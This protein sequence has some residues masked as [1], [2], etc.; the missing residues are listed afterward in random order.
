ML[1]QLRLDK[2]FDKLDE[3]RP[4]HASERDAISISLWGLFTTE[5]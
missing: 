5:R 1:K 3:S 4:D 2:R